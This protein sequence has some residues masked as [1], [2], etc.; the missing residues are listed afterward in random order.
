MYVTKVVKNV[1]FV[2]FP[3]I[4]AMLRC[5]NEAKTA[6]FSPKIRS[7]AFL[8]IEHSLR[9]KW[10]AGDPNRKN[11]WN[12]TEEQLESNGRTIGS[13]RQNNWKQSAEKL[14]SNYLLSSAKEPS[15]SP[16]LLFNICSILVQYMFNE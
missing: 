9:T 10:L 7:I 1:K 14:L 3:S 2:N 5:Q 13:K 8:N 11:N 4:F 12:Q 15:V 6:V 16:S